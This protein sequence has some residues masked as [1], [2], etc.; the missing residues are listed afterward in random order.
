L[1]AE[2]TA[3]RVADLGLGA[4][5]HPVLEASVQPADGDGRV[6]TGRVSQHRLSWLSDH[7]IG[8]STLVPGAAQLEWALRAADE[9][10]CGGVTELV[11]HAPLTVPAS[12]GLDVQVIVGA[13]DHDGHREVGVHSRADHD[14]TWVCHATG[15]LAPEPTAG[16]GP[17]RGPW[18]PSGAEPVDTAGF[19]GDTADAG[20][21]YGPAFQGVRAV[22]RHGAD[23]LAELELPDAVT[24]RDGFGIHPALLDAALHPLLLMGRFSAG[25]VWLPFSWSGVTL[26][27]TGAASARVRLSPLGEGL[28]D[29]VQVTVTDPTGAPVLD[30]ASVVLREADRRRLGAARARGAGDVYGVE[31]VPAEEAAGG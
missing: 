12:G 4:T 22:W 26:H 31:W 10:G 2:N 21:G 20:Y 16:A 11:L 7:V 15:V 28:D 29:G 8:D 3:V 17:D 23:V 27:A 5:G 9:V 25:K 6:L 13:A 30:V 18:P 14:G 1:S 19:Y 24:D